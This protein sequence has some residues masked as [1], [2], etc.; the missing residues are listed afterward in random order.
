MPPEVHRAKHIHYLLSN[1]ASTN[2]TK[3]KRAIVAE[4]FYAFVDALNITDNSN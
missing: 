4:A 1:S 3:E 2:S